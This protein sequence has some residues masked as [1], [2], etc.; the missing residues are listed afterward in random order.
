[1][2]YVCYG[3]ARTLITLAKVKGVC[4]FSY[5]FLISCLPSHLPSKQSTRQ[6]SAPARPGVT[7]SLGQG[8]GFGV[9]GLKGAVERL[10]GCRPQN[11]RFT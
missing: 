6:Q 11:W 2:W 9:R 1:M 5:N 7:K 8:S 10:N 3:A 4:K